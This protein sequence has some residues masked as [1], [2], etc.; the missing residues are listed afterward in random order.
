VGG[1]FD[2]GR[3]EILFSIREQNQKRLAEQ[4]EER[5]FVAE[6]PPSIGSMKLILL[7]RQLK[8]KALQIIV[9]FFYWLWLKYS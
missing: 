8:I 7:P 5:L 6:S 3:D 4:S 1:F 2:F 9:R